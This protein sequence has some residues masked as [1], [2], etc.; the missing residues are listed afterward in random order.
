MVAFM[1]NSIM[2]ERGVEDSEFI[3]PYYR[4]KKKAK[5]KSLHPKLKQ[6]HR[7][8]RWTIYVRLSPNDVTLTTTI[9]DSGS[10]PDRMRI[11]RNSSPNSE[12]CK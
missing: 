11:H 6:L 10:Y 12:G 7:Q 4:F 5:V 8:T 9:G 1:K 2:L 3:Y